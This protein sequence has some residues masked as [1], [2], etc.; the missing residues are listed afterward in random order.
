MT[1]LTKLT[2]WE[3]V[4]GVKNQQFKVE[5]Y[6]ESIFELIN[7]NNNEINAYITTLESRAKDKAI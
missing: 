2:L 5:E 7:K 1:K 6:V 3:V 4:D